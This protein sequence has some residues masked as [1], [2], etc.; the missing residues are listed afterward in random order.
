M[1]SV[2]GGRYYLA[3]TAEDL[4]QIYDEITAEFDRPQRSGS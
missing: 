3:P 1:A 4:R 2:T